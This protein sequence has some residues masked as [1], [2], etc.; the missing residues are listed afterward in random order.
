MIVNTEGLV[1][2]VLVNVS[3]VSNCQL[4]VSS[5]II[6]KIKIKKTGNL[7]VKIDTVL[8]NLILIE[9]CN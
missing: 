4:C 2:Q 5:A 6:K 9:N 3:N 7:T 8:I 1:S